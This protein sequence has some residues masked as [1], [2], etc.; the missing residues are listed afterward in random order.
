MDYRL[1]T[2]QL[3]ELPVNMR[4]IVQT[5]LRD[6]GI[7]YEGLI[8]ALCELPDSH[9]M[10][11][12][13][14]DAALEALIEKQWLVQLTDDPKTYKV[15]LRRRARRNVVESILGALGVEVMPQPD[16][17]SL[18]RGGNRRLPD[19]IW[20]ALD[21][22]HQ[23]SEEDAAKVISTFKEEDKPKRVTTELSKTLWDAVAAD[24]TSASSE[25]TEPAPNIRQ[26]VQRRRSIWD[27]L[28]EEDTNKPA[29]T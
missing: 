8:K 27:A 19:Q 2:Y 9:C 7:S 10:T 11:L 12:P 24:E 20:A 25:A 23:G 13:E 22:T 3:A 4:K 6:K 5:V 16:D 29:E 18:R 21:K 17:V 14:L 26:E 1:S 28:D 15:H